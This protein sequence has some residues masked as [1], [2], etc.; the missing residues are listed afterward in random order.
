MNR[1]VEDKKGLKPKYSGGIMGDLYFQLYTIFLKFHFNDHEFVL[2]FIISKFKRKKKKINDQI[3]T[4]ERL[5]VNY[6][7]YS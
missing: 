2:C 4:K 6:F 3:S 5:F 1:L 7:V